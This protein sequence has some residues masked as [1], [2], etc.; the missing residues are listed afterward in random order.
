MKHG[1]I[2]KLIKREKIGKKIICSFGDSN[3][4]S[5]HCV[6]KGVMGSNEDF[7]EKEIN[8]GMWNKKSQWPKHTCE[9][10]GNK[11]SLQMKN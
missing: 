11:K 9:K 4:S 6:I 1:K 2:K 7:E 3:Q 10:T 5:H 8:K